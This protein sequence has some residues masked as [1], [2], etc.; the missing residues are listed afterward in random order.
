MATLKRVKHI[1]TVLD[2]TTMEFKLENDQ[3]ES[4]AQFI[5]D[6]KLIFNNCRSYNNETTTYYKNASKLE[7]GFADVVKERFVEYS[8]LV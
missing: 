1:L 7:K 2:L 4:V 5:Y 8:A 3:Y 6:A